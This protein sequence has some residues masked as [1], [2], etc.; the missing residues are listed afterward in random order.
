MLTIQ[1]VFATKSGGHE[2]NEIRKSLALLPVMEMLDICR[3]VL[4]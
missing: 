3:V 2:L 1:A 4:P